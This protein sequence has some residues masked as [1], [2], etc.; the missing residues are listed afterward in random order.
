MSTEEDWKTFLLRHKWIPVSFLREKYALRRHDVDNFRRKPGVKQLLQPWRIRLDQEPE[1][2]RRIF[3][4]AW[5]FY[6]EQISGLHIDPSTT[7]WITRLVSLRSISRD[8]NGMGFLANSRYY[9]IMCPEALSDFRK[10]G[11]TN[12]ALGTHLFWPGADLLKRC[13]VLPFM[14]QQTHKATLEFVNVDDMIEHVYLSFV[15]PSERGNPDFAKEVFLARSNET[16]F[17]T[18]ETLAAYGVPYNFYSDDGGLRNVLDRICEK[19]RQDL[20]LADPTDTAWSTSR[21]RK[22]HPRSEIDRCRYCGLCPV[23]LHHLLPRSDY[24]DLTFHEENVVPL[25]IQIH[26]LITRNQLNRTLAG[27]Y[28]S[29][30]KKWHRARDG[31]RATAFDEVM[32]QVHRHVYGETIAA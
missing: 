1:Q 29:A 26:G 11:Y 14:F 32:R 18:A 8:P 12:T 30:T 6:I 10:H 21:F 28:A 16:G 5:Q 15:A 9:E 27:M 17:L 19:Y 7:E 22:L 31:Q 20:G 3:L 4:D 24:P 25:C 23:D 13:S 2:L